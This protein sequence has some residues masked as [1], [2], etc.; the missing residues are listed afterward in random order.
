MAMIRQPEN[1]PATVKEV[2]R[3]LA[4]S[5]E[6][7]AHALGVSFATVN[8]WENGKTIPSKLA[9]RQFEQFCKD[10]VKKGNLVLNEANKCPVVLGEDAPGANDDAR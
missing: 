6:E 4:L 8:R 7:L 9:Q 1:F 10:N 2:R 3:Q 5:Q